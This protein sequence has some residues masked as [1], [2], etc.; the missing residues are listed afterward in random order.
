MDFDFVGARVEVRQ[1]TAMLCLLELGFAEL[2][3]STIQA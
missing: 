2:L 1:H 3:A